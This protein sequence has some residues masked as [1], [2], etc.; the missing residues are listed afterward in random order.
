[1]VP[2]DQVDALQRR[3]A[4]LRATA[5]EWVADEEFESLSFVGFY[6]DFSINVAVPPTSFCTLTIEGLAETGD[7]ADDGS[8]PAPDG[9]G[10][11]LQLLQPATITDGVLASISV[12][13]DDYPVW[14]AST[15]ASALC[16]Y[17]RAAASPG[18]GRAA[19][20]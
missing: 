13:E 17:R 20:Q 8:D 16:G 14:V 6:K 1:M 4:D 7:G 11:T 19:C 5:V 12:A 10:S 3:L 15:T 18:V 9:E 2:F